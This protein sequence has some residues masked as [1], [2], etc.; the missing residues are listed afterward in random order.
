MNSDPKRF[1][2]RQGDVLVTRRT[3]SVPTDAQPVARE[4]GRVV[5]AHG[6]ATGH[7]HAITGHGAKLFRR[8][9]LETMLHVT[10]KGGVTLRHEEHGS[11]DLPEGDYDV[12]RK[13]E[14]TGE[15][16][17]MVMD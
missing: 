9:S 7:A 10:S 16:E 3:D 6:E 13:R 5:L 8:G 2:I 1:Q 12:V 15:N 17:R 4:G 14:W 11:V